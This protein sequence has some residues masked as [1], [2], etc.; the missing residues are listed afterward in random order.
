MDE[1]RCK[2]CGHRWIKRVS[3]DP[4]SC[5]KCKNRLWNQDRPTKKA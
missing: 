5:P 4:E 3:K 1:L 2:R